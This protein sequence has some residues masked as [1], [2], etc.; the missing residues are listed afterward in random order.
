MDL[1]SAIKFI[2]EKVIAGVAED[3]ADAVE[4]EWDALSLSQD[5]TRY[6]AKFGLS[7][8]AKLEQR[9]KR[10]HR[11]PAIGVFTSDGEAWDTYLASLTSVYDNAEGRPQPLIEFTAE[12]WKAFGE[13]M[14]QMSRSFETRAKLGRVAFRLLQTHKVSTTKELPTHV[15]ADLAAQAD[16]ALFGDEEWHS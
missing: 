15:L 10:Y 14:T 6:L 8:K 13:R 16:K 12:D 1:E 4:Q 3:T 7:E 11:Q 5:D 2:W 9:S